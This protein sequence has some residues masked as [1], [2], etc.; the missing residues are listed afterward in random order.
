MKRCISGR[1]LFWSPRQ[2]AKGSQAA[3]VW[4]VC[5]AARPSILTTMDC[6]SYALMGETG[7]QE[8]KPEGFIS[9]PASP[10]RLTES[11]CQAHVDGIHASHR[12][13]Q[14]LPAEFDFHR[15]FRLQDSTSKQR[16]NRDGGASCSSCSK[17]KMVWILSRAVVGKFLINPINMTGPR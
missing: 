6:L 12:F 8:G 9:R 14:V 1:T 2:P 4:S 10:L 7:K 13:D 16:K 11:F 3:G 5:S 15:A 17:S